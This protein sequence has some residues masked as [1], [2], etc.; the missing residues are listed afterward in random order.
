MWWT[1]SKCSSGPSYHQSDWQSSSGIVQ[2]VRHKWTGQFIA[3]KVLSDRTLICLSIVRLY[4]DQ[5]II[6]VADYAT[7]YLR[8]YT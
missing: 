6:V 3:L 8:R 5:C 7:K 1:S 2:L 4:L